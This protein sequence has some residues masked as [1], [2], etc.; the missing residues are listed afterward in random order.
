[1]THTKEPWEYVE[2]SFN[3][4]HDITKTY[5]AIR[6]EGIN[7]ARMPSDKDAK[8]IVACVNACAV[9]PNN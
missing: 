4:G 2:E 9:S 1:M 5:N 7:I 6:S 8:R 3:I